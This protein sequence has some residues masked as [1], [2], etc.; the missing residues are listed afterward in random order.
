M[1]R[2]IILKMLPAAL[3]AA[4][5]CTVSGRISSAALTGDVNSDGLIDSKD[6]SVI[7]EE[8][9]L[10]SVGNAGSFNAAEKA[11]ADVN[12]DGLTD[13][14]DASAILSYYTYASTGGE[15]SLPEY[16]SRLSADKVLKA[17]VI[18]DKDYSLMNGRYVALDISIDELLETFDYNDIVTV[19]LN[20][21]ELDMP[22]SRYV[23]NIDVCPLC[24]YAD[25]GNQFLFGYEGDVVYITSSYE[26]V[27]LTTGLFRRAP[28]DSKYYYEFNS[29][30]GSPVVAE[31]SLKEKSGYS[32]LM[33]LNNL[34]RDYVRE[35][36]Q[37]LTDE[38]YANFRMIKMGDIAEGVLYR[39]SNPIDPVLSRNTYA[40][41]AAEEHGVKTFINLADSEDEAE[42]F[43]G[44]SDSY[45]SKQ[46]VIYLDMPLVFGEDTFRERLA[47]GFRFI[48]DNEGPYLM[49]CMEGKFRCGFVSAVLECFMGAD[50]D[51]VE[52]D[53]VRSYINYFR[54]PD[55]LH[56][57]IKS[58][59]DGFLEREFGIEDLHFADTRAEAEKYI[60]GL[61]LTESEINRLRARLSGK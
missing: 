4:V 6:A 26:F 30:L 54:V 11:A 19:K 44:F 35:K 25:P 39:S 16:V 57:E 27:G 21:Y 3:A 59:I 8:Y 29:D 45:Y 60:R 61:G 20:G 13:A 22:L 5:V 12:E 10:L 9:S 38:E 37:N 51:E 7:L 31:I 41:K 24:L 2:K 46:N 14:S 33:P 47:A 50:A 42:R 53:F 55:E 18:E 28:E 56:P 48:A 17:R 52:E 40:D 36:Y 58:L 15:H 43:Y 49:H 1:R 34:V 23:T 32:R